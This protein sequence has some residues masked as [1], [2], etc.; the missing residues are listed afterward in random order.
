MCSW[1]EQAGLKA[2]THPTVTSPGPRCSPLVV[3]FLQ[4]GV[5]V[6][7]ARTDRHLTQTHPGNGSWKGMLWPCM[8]RMSPDFFQYYL[9]REEEGEGS[10]Q[11]QSRTWICGL[12]VGLQ[13][14]LLACLQCEHGSARL[15]VLVP[16][17]IAALLIPVYIAVLLQQGFRPQKHVPATAAS[18]RW[19]RELVSCTLQCSREPRG[20]KKRGFFGII[21]GW[22]Q[23]SDGPRI[24]DDLC[25]ARFKMT[26]KMRVSK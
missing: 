16:V 25:L 14:Y 4:Q 23:L 22:G 15:L 13:W 6:R 24:E 10:L 19:H 9:A 26:S 12:R 20:K 21:W 17:L 7:P 1:L 3:S 5:S 18:E 8:R 2:E 11:E